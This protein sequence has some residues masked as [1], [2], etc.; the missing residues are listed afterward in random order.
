MAQIDPA[1]L[2]EHQGQVALIEDHGPVQQFAAEDPDNALADGIYPRVLAARLDLNEP[3]LQR[4]FQATF[5][6]SLKQFA[7]IAHIE[8]VWSGLWACRPRNWSA[9]LADETARAVEPMVEGARSGLRK[10]AGGK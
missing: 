4:S 6:M 2:A 3:H 8:R 7:R 9:C 5:G 1:V 10:A